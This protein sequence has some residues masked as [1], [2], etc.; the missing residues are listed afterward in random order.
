VDVRI[1]AV[2]FGSD[3][4]LIDSTEAHRRVWSA[5][6]AADEVADDLCEVA[7]CIRLLARA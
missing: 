3:G 1:A 2:L 5:W 4:V 7:E 6:A